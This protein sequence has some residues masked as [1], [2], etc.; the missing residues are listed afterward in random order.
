MDKKTAD[1]QAMDSQAMDAPIN[2]LQAQHLATQTA[3]LQAQA[4]SITQPPPQDF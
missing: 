1:P 4:E 3:R 2:Q